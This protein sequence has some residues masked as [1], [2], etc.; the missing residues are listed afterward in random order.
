MINNNLSIKIG[1]LGSTRG[2]IL[3]FIINSVK[4]GILKDKAEIVICISNKKNSG[5]LENARNL[6]IKTKYIPVSSNESREIYDSKLSNELSNNYV[7]LVICIGWMRI[8]SREFTEKWKNN[9]MNVHP[10]LLPEF[11]GGMD[12]D[13]HQSVLDAKKE[14][15]GCTIHIVSDVVDS[16]LI[17][18]Q[19]ECKVLPNDTAIS[20]KNRVQELEGEAYVD[21]I[22]KW[23]NEIHTLGI[24][25]RDQPWKG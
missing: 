3:P 16:G 5:I 11:A 4:K 25:P 23:I 13:V 12:K 10:S 18:N 1:V 9:C 19:K 21:S 24:E 17:I 7:D 14:K 8:L 15:T 20:L 2:T 6:N 22:L